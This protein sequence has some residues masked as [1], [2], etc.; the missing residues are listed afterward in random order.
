MLNVFALLGV[1]ELWLIACAAFVCLVAW[2]VHQPGRGILMWVP[3]CLALAALV[4]PPDPLT[5]VIVAAPCLAF[6]MFAARRRK[7]T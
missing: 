3:A 4:T 2:A 7:R 5:M 6:L 1:W